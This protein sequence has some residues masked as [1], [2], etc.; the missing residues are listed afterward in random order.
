MTPKLGRLVN[1]RWRRIAGAAQ[2]LFCQYGREK[3]SRRD[4]PP[5]PLNSV[6]ILG[7]GLMGA[8]LLM[9]L[10]VKRGFRSE[11]K[12]SPAGHKSCAEVQLGSA[13]GQS[14]RR[15]LKA[16]ERDK[17]LALISGTRTIA[18]LPIAIWLLKR[19]LKISIKTT[20]GGGS[21]AKLRYSYHLSSNT[22]SLPIGDIA[23]HAARPEKLLACIS[24]VRW[25][26]C[27]W[28][29]LFSCEYIGANHRH[30]GKTGEKT[31]KTPIVVR[32]KAGFYV[33]RILALT[34]MKLSACWPKAS[35]LSISIRASEIWVSGRPNPTFGWG[36]I[37]TGT[38][39]MPVLEAAYGERFSRLQ[40]LFLQFWTTIAK[41]EK[42]AGFLSLWSERA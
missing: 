22:S 40:M 30:H 5:A 9:S 33:N 24:S 13:W 16:S 29:R 35:V 37:D 25:K 2:Y 12:I 27:R 32:D 17:Q 39:I 6:G 8:V 20:D 31:G 14:C 11:L 1:W 42:M 18:A 19:C 34:S 3:R 15:H 4:A 21:G 28:W 38:K 7:G 26:K 41:A 23:A 36:R 10:L